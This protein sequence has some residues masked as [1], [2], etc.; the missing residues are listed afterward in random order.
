[1]SSALGVAL[2]AGGAAAAAAG[3]ATIGTAMVKG[4]QRLD[5]IDQAKAKLTGLGNSA[6]DVSKI[7]DNALASVKGTAFGL[8]DAA[9]LAGVMVAAG[10]KPGQELE[11]TLKRVAD[12]AAI[13]GTDLADMGQIWGKAA[14]KGKIDGEIVNQLLERQ[15]PI[16]DILG[17]RMGK[18]AEE[19]ATM[20][21]K[22]KIS[23]QDFSDAMQ[24]RVGGAALKT[25]ETVRGAFNNMTAALGRLGAS[26][27]S[28]FFARLPGQM[29]G[30]TSA[31]DAMEPRVKALAEALDDKI[32]EEW[33][34]KIQAA[35][36]SA[37][38]GG[39]LTDLA[40]TVRGLWESLEG[41][42]APLGR[43]MTELGRAS[44]AIGIGTWQLFLAAL[45]AAAAT[46]DVIAPALSATASLMESNR[47][48]VTALVA[49]WV[50]FRTVP[51]LI[52]RVG[53]PVAALTAQTRAATAATAGFGGAYR[54]SLVWMA[55]ANPQMSRAGVHM[56]V[57]GANARSAATSIGGAL[58]NAG[59]ATAAMFGGPFG[60]A[61]AAGTAG[62]LAIM[63]SEKRHQQQ[64]E[65]TRAAVQQMTEAQD[66][67]GQALMKTRGE[68]DES[69]WKI[70]ETQV[71]A[72]TKSVNAAAEAD[73]KWHHVFGDAII[74]VGTFGAV[75]ADAAGQADRNAQAAQAQQ[76][77]IEAL[78]LSTEQMTKKLYGTRAEFGTMI[79]NLRQ[80]GE[81]GWKTANDLMKLRQEYDAQVAVSRR[82]TPGAGELADA[83][84]TLG[85]EGSSAADKLKALRAA[86]D[87]LSPARGK[88]EAMRQYGQAVREVATAAAG[89]DGTAFNADGS[90][91]EMS[92]AG[93]KLAGVLGELVDK[94]LQVAS[95]GG[96]MN[97]V[98]REN[99]KAF[100]QLADATG[101]SV[102]DIRKIFND[103]G[104]SVVDVAV[105]VQGSTEVQAELAAIRKSM[106]SVPKG[107]KLEIETGKLT[108]G[109]IQTLEKLGIQV[110]KTP[111]GKTITIEANDKSK[112]ALDL[113]AQKVT[114]LGAKT[115]NPT[116]DL[117]KIP[118]D[119][120][121]ATVRAQLQHLHS[122]HVSPEADLVIEKLLQGKTISM[123][124]LQVL[125]AAVANPKAEM[126][127]TAILAKIAEINR[128]LDNAARPR[129]SIIEVLHTGPGNATD[130]FFSGATP[131]AHG[132]IRQYL[133]GGIAA[134][135]A[136][137]NGGMRKLPDKAL[138]Q[139][140]DPRG[141]LVQ[142]AEPETGG[143]AFIPL[144]KGKRTR[145]TAILATVAEMF[146]LSLVPQDS[147]SGTLGA[148]AGGAVSKLLKSAG[149]DG[150]TKFADGGIL[151]RFADGEGASR[152]LT[153][154]P[155]VWGGVNWGDC[156]GAMSAFARK[157]V[158]LPP[159]G[160][161]FSTATMGAQLQQM[162]FSMGRGSSG[163][164]RF[165]WYNG[166]PGGGHTA[167]T[168][169]DGTN[170]EMG[171]QNGGGMVGGSVGAD[172]AQ[173]TD[174]A[175]LKIA[176]PWKDPGDDPG[177]YVLRP[178]GTYGPPA[179]DP[180]GS[181]PDT[182]D[183]F[184][185]KLGNAAGA[186]VS[187]QLSSLFGVL[188]INDSPGA[189]KAYNEFQNQRSQNLGQ[190]Q[191]P[192]AVQPRDPGTDKPKEGEDT[193]VPTLTGDSVK[194]AFKRGLREAWRT[195]PEWDATDWIVNK[196]STWNPSARNGKYW[197]LIQGGEE[198]YR[199]AGVDPTTTDPAE[200]AKAYDKYV[201]GRYRLPT[202]AK[203]F[204]EQ[205]NWYDRGGIAKDVGL[206]LKNTNRPERVL[207][208]RQTTSFEEMV[209]RDFQS[210]IGTDQVIAKLDQ[211]V[212]LLAERDGGDIH[213]HFP[214]YGSA[215]R[216]AEEVSRDQRQRALLGGL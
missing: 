155:Y 169:P 22:G 38:D 90:L 43:V 212:Q 207:S 216:D 98:T 132:S 202:A 35:L 27:M 143:E 193:G 206:M 21:S 68:M 179:T 136:Y 3:V 183:T 153:G 201:E 4:F 100:Q 10:I 51:G 133:H 167:G 57:L 126:D 184:S 16:Y 24:D 129:R 190:R 11:A 45:N 79:H 116:I 59:A 26:A 13:A 145:S 150:L 211:I 173:F 160:G 113:V 48:A 1:M 18:S 198:V 149:V 15:I 134:A 63:S 28:P 191:S 96:D 123:S 74:R 80:Q 213:N 154:A 12:S 127:A 42:A 161:R 195:G 29:G 72:Y 75:Q 64:L 185:G 189:L 204:H 122:Q 181:T 87:A 117:N 114:E 32:F 119:A 86:V 159:F 69:T 187:G 135:E 107:K 166:G 62:V 140:P 200:Q 101:K 39:A 171:G 23:F 111:N 108:Q 19:I 31:L 148:I 92:E 95:T 147:I 97:R 124:E 138:I 73:G 41:V 176:D 121:D 103:L 66:E 34:P 152:P 67:L 158:G 44:A 115:A 88:V 110:E 85:D 209:K 186:F 58:K 82:V 71:E 37:R 105:E 8:G 77:A 172:S 112:A 131:N 196:E 30:V 170:I 151:R 89:I 203:A 163:D 55:Q 214:D 142:W 93:D 47:S 205:N 83:V 118:F 14:A 208:P 156:S 6:G 215:K 7:M 120:K 40:T 78:G 104:G 50:A 54:Q 65:A 49:A 25:G 194:D 174:H 165:G 33:G 2:K 94:S 53:G 17:K 91:N 199:A 99:E 84:R 164:L 178:D 20:V 182:S 162:G 60:L 70:A 175:Y 106:D 146:G 36:A 210:G 177:G 137:A 102:D 144:A 9:S 180:R 76:R 141:G 168:L 130:N 61:L 5:A 192:G 52:S 197:G 188:G 157:A 128:Q 56:A 81:A 109:A 125:D 139:K 46:L